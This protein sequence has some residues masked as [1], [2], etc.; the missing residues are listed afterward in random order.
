MEQ[1]INVIYKLAESPD[2]IC[3]ELI[4]NLTLESCQADKNGDQGEKVKDGEKEETEMDG[5]GEK[6]KEK[7]AG[8]TEQMEERQTDN[9][10]VELILTEA[11]KPNSDC[12]GL[13]CSSKTH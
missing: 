3:G 9:G 13:D 10:M 8:E 5:D 7:E 11:K 2:K 12:I 1:G 4:K 6:E